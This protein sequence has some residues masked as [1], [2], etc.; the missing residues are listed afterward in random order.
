VP[1]DYLG[2]V[3]GALGLGGVVFALIEQANYGWQDPIVLVPLTVGALCLAGFLVRERRAAHPMLP[4]G[5]FRTRN[6]AVGNLATA[7]IY[8]ALSVASLVIVVYL[9]QGIGLSATLAG[10]VL[11]PVTILNIALSSWFGTLAGRYGSRWFMAGGPFL[12]AVGFL[13]LL[14]I[15]EP[16]NFVT[17]ALP[18]VLLFGLGLT[19]TIA[20]LTSA[21]LGA[22]D[23]RQSG[24]ASATNNAVSR[25]AGLIAIAV[26][27]LVIGIEV[28]G[29]WFDRALILCAALMLVGAV[30][31]A[32]GIRNT[33]ASAEDR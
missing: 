4:L 32:I 27:G 5:L 28:D 3:L 15:D 31:S 29:A 33:P 7:A 23:S 30:V 18:G 11:L 12:A 19:M 20:P 6:F 21:I 14:A 13:L 25:V 8:A 1:I 24:I 26:L 22:I 2:A 16:F 9:Q 10:L 17:Q